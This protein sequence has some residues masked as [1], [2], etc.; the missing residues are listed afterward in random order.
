[1]PTLYSES[2]LCEAPPTALP[3]IY[4]RNRQ[5][6]LL[7]AQ[8]DKETVEARCAEI[9]SENNTRALRDA[10]TA[11]EARQRPQQDSKSSVAAYQAL[12][13]S[14][15]S[16]LDAV[17]KEHLPGGDEDAERGAA[18]LLEKMKDVEA[19]REKEW[20]NYQRSHRSVHSEA[21]TTRQHFVV[22]GEDEVPAARQA[23]RPR[24]FIDF[25][26]GSEPLGRVVLELYSQECPAAANNFRNL[27]T[28]C[29]GFCSATGLRLD[30]LGSPAQYTKGGDVV[31]CGLIGGQSISSTGSPVSEES[32]RYKHVKRGIISMVSSGPNH[33][34][35]AFTISLGPVPR[36]DYVQ[37]IV[38]MV[39]DG[40]AVLNQIEA[41]GGKP[42]HISFCGLLSGERPTGKRRLETL[43]QDPK[44]RESALAWSNQI[45]PLLWGGGMK[46]APPVSAGVVLTGLERIDRMLP[47]TVPTRPLF[48]D[49][50]VD[51]VPGENNVVPVS[52]RLGRPHHSRGVEED[53]EGGGYE[54][55]KN[56]DDETWDDEESSFYG[57]E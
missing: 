15:F 28:G 16:E 22:S 10:L 12:Q 51:A 1:M 14:V 44:G 24:A 8:D 4:G 5:T 55:D 20:E 31:S 56:S 34:G 46:A 2:V 9:T 11:F 41:L 50:V 27:L 13:D 57:D 6:T 39:I 33:I 18:A 47:A 42:A 21:A 32:H 29:A 53:A 49:G 7:S 40:M 45:G 38:G 30:Y 35:S 54:D 48:G 26:S 43:I 36:L 23:P 17:I 19:R 52:D 37:Q 3:S 25:S